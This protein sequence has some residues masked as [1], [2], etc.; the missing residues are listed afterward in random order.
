LFDTH[1]GKAEAVPEKHEMSAPPLYPPT[2]KAADVA[3]NLDPQL[4][5][6]VLRK[7]DEVLE[8]DRD[9]IVVNHVL[10]AP[11]NAIIY[12]AMFSSRFP[13]NSC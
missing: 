6:R 8:L 4:W 11:E 1:A 13:P 3:A 2:A 9:W 5:N 12:D 7:L 10:L